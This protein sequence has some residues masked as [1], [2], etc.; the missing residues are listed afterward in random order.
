MG[1]QGELAEIAA[2]A[3]AAHTGHGSVIRIEGEAGAGKS[4]LVAHFVHDVAHHMVVLYAACQS[5]AQN[6][7]YFAARQ[8]VRPL[9]GLDDAIAQPKDSQI[10]A[11]EATLRDRDPA[12]LLRLPL[13][14]ELLGLPIQDNPTTAAF[15][16]RMRQ[17]ALAAL[18]VEIISKAAQEHPFVLIIEDAY[19]LDEASRGLVLAMA[20]IV[21]LAK[22]MLM[23]VQRPLG[24]EQ[25]VL[26]RELADLPAQ[27]RIV[28]AELD[29]AGTAQMVAGRLQ[30]AIEPL[31]LDIVHTLAQG[32][33]F[34]TEEL[35]DALHE[36]EL[37]AID[38][39]RWQLAG[40]LVD[41]LR[42]ANC[43][44]RDDEAWR[45]AENAPLSAVQVG[46]PS[47]IHGLVLS[48]LD[49]LPEIAKLTLKV[50]SVIGRVFELDLLAAAH[51]SA[52]MQKC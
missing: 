47:S 29:R 42:R 36:G 31:A 41:S 15:D 12:W 17:E 8:F 27:R 51:P 25:E 39:G 43:L 5:T 24:I 28:L 3:R 19:W 38:E 44:V 35:V 26:A 45:L 4:H 1:R 9:L 22:I 21:P 16:T 37:I 30:G 20:R 34:F 6:T 33:P 50:A 7:A 49:R 32:N 10:A 18:V 23:L 40:G 48:R 13:L 46:V 2:A 11:L 14:G 52:R